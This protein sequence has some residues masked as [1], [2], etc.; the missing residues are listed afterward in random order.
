MVNLNAEPLFS[1]VYTSLL[2]MKLTIPKRKLCVLSACYAAI[3]RSRDLSI[4]TYSL[5]FYLNKTSGL[6]HCS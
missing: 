1:A 3:D 2:I 5:G 6:T 4:S